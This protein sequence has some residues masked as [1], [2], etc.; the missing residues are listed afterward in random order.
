MSVDEKSIC[1]TCRTTFGSPA[2]A[3]RHAREQSHAVVIELTDASW[4]EY[5]HGF[6][7][8]WDADM[9]AI[10]RWQEATGKELVWPDHADLVVW[11]LEQLELAEAKSAIAEPKGEV[12]YCYLK[13]ALV[14]VEECAT[15]CGAPE[16]RPQ[17]WADKG[18][19][20]G[21][22]LGGEG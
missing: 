8:R 13:Q 10:R 3:R 9:R 22:D 14:G 1:K 12:V 5:G 17:C 2:A 15:S 16:M 4:E 7:L 18:I 21:Y 20:E 11:L 6:R 19:A